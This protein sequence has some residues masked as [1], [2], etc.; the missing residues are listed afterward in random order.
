M[1]QEESELC[2]GDSSV[3]YEVHTDGDGVHSK[4]GTLDQ[5]LGGQEFVDQLAYK[6]YSKR[7]AGSWST[8]QASSWWAIEG[9]SRN[10]QL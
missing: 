1:R 2:R 5:L 10:L 7:R 8:K 4:E 3:I 9:T 6:L